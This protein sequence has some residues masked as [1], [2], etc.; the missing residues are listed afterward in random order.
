M[1]NKFRQWK[2]M[3]KAEKIVKIL[4][5]KGY[6]AI[7]AKDHEEAKK[8]VIDRVKKGSTVG[9]GGYSS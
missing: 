4:N 6:E 9:L 1:Q 7:L 8:L 5:E 3:K 2:N